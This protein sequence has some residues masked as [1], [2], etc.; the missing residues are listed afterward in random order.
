MGY[1]TAYMPPDTSMGVSEPARD[2]GAQTSG[3]GTLQGLYEEEVRR[4][5]G[6]D[7]EAQGSEQEQQRP[8]P[9]INTGASA[10]DA[11]AL[12][13]AEANIDHMVGDTKLIG[14]WALIAAH[15]LIDL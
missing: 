13:E 10:D 6:L 14:S 11:A 2:E 15:Q 3:N 7:L 4:M 9:N 12:Y 1:V 8:S 5:D